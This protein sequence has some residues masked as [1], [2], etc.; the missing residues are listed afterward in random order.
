MSAPTLASLS[1]QG[2]FVYVAFDQ[3]V[4]VDSGFETSVFTVTVNAA[5]IAVSSYTWIMNGIALQLASAPPSGTAA[6]LVTFNNA[7]A[8]WKA[9]SD[10]TPATTFTAQ[11]ALW[12]LAYPPS[13]LTVKALTFTNG[14]VTGA[15]QVALSPVD[16]QLMQEYGPVTVSTTA[17]N[18][19]G[20]PPC[21]LI[22]VPGHLVTLVDG[23]V[24]QETISGTLNPKTCAAIAAAQ[25]QQVVLARIQAAINTTRRMDVSINKGVDTIV[26]V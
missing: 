21:G 14:N 22:N 24:V 6:V 16:S 15:I 12:Q 17:A 8:H 3:A 5:P 26:T 19:A 1:W 20:T 9:T 7:A 23:V 10:A 25:W 18:L 2:P 4:T 13:V 11:S